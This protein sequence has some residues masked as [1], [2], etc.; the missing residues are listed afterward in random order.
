MMILQF[1]MQY[2]VIIMGGWS[3][4]HVGLVF[5]LIFKIYL[6]LFI[7]RLWE[8]SMKQHLTKSTAWACLSNFRISYCC[9][10]CAPTSI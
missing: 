8:R 1:Y 6:I 3:I 7:L 4:E 10:A 2:T 9:V 5:P